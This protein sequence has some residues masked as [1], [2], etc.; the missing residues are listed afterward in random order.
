MGRLK[1]LINHSVTLG[2][3]D[4]ECI[5]DSETSLIVKRAVRVSRFTPDER[6]EKERERLS[7]FFAVSPGEGRTPRTGVEI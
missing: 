1:I 6:E 7:R 4:E 3:A 2:Q 5:V